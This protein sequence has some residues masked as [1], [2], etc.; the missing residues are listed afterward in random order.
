MT[1]TT[2]EKIITFPC[3]VS[4]SPSLNGDIN[5]LQ[6]NVGCVHQLFVCGRDQRPQ[7]GSESC[8]IKCCKQQKSPDALKIINLQFKCIYVSL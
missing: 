8:Y 3:A 2:T 6:S 7:S 1:L 4:F 5:I